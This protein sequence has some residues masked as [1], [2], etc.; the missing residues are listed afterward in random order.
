MKLL[1]RDRVS[2]SIWINNTGYFYFEQNITPHR[3]FGKNEMHDGIEYM[4]PENLNIPFF[5]EINI[6]DKINKNDD[7]Y[8]DLN[9]SLLDI[10]AN[11]GC[12][13]LYTNFKHN[14][15]FEPNKIIYHLLATNL[16]MHDKYEIS[17]LYNVCL[18][19][20][21]EIL[22]YDGAR[23]KEIDENC[24]FFYDYTHEDDN[25]R[26][27]DSIKTHTIDEYNCENLGLIKIDV[28]GMEEKILRGSIGTIIRNNYPPI[29]FELWNVGEWDMTQEKHDSLEKFLKDLGYTIFWYWGDYETHLAVHLN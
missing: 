17:S 18:S 25:T 5:S 9:K 16:I 2:P 4:K 12:Y 26:Y 13:S 24:R 27:I 20:R 28:E 8:F 19:D 29:L 7:N 14:Y 21:V 3:D 11:V 10:G 22:E 15:C 23:C 1:Y 6:I